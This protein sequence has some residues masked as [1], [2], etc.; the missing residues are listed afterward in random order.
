MSMHALLDR[1]SAHAETRAPRVEHQLKRFRPDVHPRVMAFARL[2]PWIADLAVSFPALIFAIAFPRRGVD[3]RAALRLVVEG[4]PLSTIAPALSVASWL[5]AFPPEAFAT[6]IPALPDTN[7]F[8]HRIANH[9]PRR[10]W[11]D[12]VARPHQEPARITRRSRH[13]ARRPHRLPPL[14]AARD[15]E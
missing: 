13:A 1:G 4:A 6:P 11:L 15:G 10:E 14:H 3:A 2:H 7:F 8:R 12:D 5:R 9:F